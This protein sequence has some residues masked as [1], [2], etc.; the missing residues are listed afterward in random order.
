MRTRP[1]GS[2]DI[3]LSTVIMGTWQSGKAMWS[4]IEDAESLKAIRAAFDAGITTFDTAEVYGNGHSERI[5]GKA[6]ADVRDH[7]I[8]A[9]K[10][11]S[12]HLA[13]NQV[14]AA[15]ERSLRNLGTDY[16][17]LYQIHWPPGSFGHPAVPLEES[18]DA[19]MTLKEQ[20]KIRA[21]GVSNFDRNLLEAARAYAPIESLQPPYSLFWRSMEK[22]TL[23]WCRTEEITTLAYSPMAQGILAGKFGPT[24]EFAKGDHRKANR[25]FQPDIYPTVLTA[26]ERLRSIANVYEV[27]L[28]QLALAWV[29]AQPYT[30]AIA[31]ARSAEQSIG[32]AAAMEISLTADTLAEMDTIGRTVTDLLD[33]NPVQWQW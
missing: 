22:D 10:V 12:N 29:I 30:C 8:L 6:L 27:T 24:L 15:C 9:T 11:F 18:L 14:V 5:V 13:R 4:G 26:L 31:G 25:L 33:D 2:T 20:G 28:A 21:I 23:T 32:N 19:L 3:Q 17:D 7:V 1:L 16:I